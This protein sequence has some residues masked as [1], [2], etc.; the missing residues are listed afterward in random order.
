MNQ[1]PEETWATLRQHYDNILRRFQRNLLGPEG[2]AIPAAVMISNIN[3][4]IKDMF[5]WNII[6]KVALYKGNIQDPNRIREESLKIQQ[7]YNMKYEERREELQKSIVLQF[8]PMYDL[9]KAVW[10]EK[11]LM[12]MTPPKTSRAPRAAL[13]TPPKTPRKPRANSAP[14]PKTTPNQRRAS[15]SFGGK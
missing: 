1:P 4:A 11:M 2:Q 14:L 8:E 6:N 15:A 3:I 10:E 7:M 5:G 13:A 12:P 9:Y